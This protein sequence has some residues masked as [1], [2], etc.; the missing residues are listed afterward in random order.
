MT[1]DQKKC[2]ST[3]IFSLA[4][5]GRI[6]L[7]AGSILAFGFA[8]HAARADNVKIL[9]ATAEVQANGLYAFS[10]TL[11]HA[12][13]GWTHYADRWEIIGENNAV[14]GV[15]TLYHPHENNVPF[16]RSLANVKV[17]IGTLQVSVRAN[18][19]VDGLTPYERVI[20]LPPR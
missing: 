12:D 9:D 1:L 2:E 19:S 14:L 5:I 13:E 18:C 16:T 8:Q 15:R 10:V 17:P 7:L 3:T 11:E 20:E 4:K 6:G